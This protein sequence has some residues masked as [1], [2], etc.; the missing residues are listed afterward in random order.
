MQRTLAE[1]DK[2]DEAL[3]LRVPRILLSTELLVLFNNSAL[4]ILS[5]LIYYIYFR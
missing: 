2:S 3:Q 1:R 4:L 5:S